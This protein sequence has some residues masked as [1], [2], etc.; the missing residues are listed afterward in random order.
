MIDDLMTVTAIK[1]VVTGKWG[2]GDPKTSTTAPVQCW[3]REITSYQEPDKIASFEGR[4]AMG[5]FPSDHDIEAGDI[6]E[7]QGSFWQVARLTEGRDPFN[8]GSTEFKKA[9]FDRHKPL[10]S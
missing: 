10:V 1:T 2:S 7:I 6:Y 8:G 4:D 3:F 5:W 9:L